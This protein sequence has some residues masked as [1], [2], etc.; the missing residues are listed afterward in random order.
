MTKLGHFHFLGTGGSMGIPLIGCRCAVCQS[1]SPFNHR[2]RP[3]GLV[4]VGNKHIL[5][6]CGP[7]F[8]EQALRHNL[9]QI[10]GLILTHP[11]YDH[12]AG[13]DELRVYYMRSK[14]PLPCL[15]SRETALD[16]QKRFYYMFE[17]KSFDS[18][19]T[20][21]FALQFLEGERG[22]TVFQGL[23]IRYMTYE[24]VGMLV[25]GFRFGDL[26]YVSDIRKYPETIF[27]DL[28]GINVLILSA[29]R[30]TPS[31]MHFHVDEAIDF[32]MRTGAKKTWLT[33]IAH[34][35]DHD[36]TN[37]YLPQSVRMAYDGLKIEFQ[38]DII[39]ERM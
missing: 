25:N 32:A 27:E 3:S 14:Q 29:L 1:Q 30:F 6:D 21:K 17:E 11:H 13:V 38:A 10:E 4:V 26:A 19:L 18:K 31:H 35:L 9:D 28:D 2:L 39:S 34:E 22:I 33:H 7:D 16:L 5:V 37:E 23:R 24:Q 15:L 20:T 36:K 8:R 12:T